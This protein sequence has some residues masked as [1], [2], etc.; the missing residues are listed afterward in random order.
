L[1]ITWLCRSLCIAVPC[2]R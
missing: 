2:R 1:H